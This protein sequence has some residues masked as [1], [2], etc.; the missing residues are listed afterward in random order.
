MQADIVN[1]AISRLSLFSDTMLSA[2]PNATNG[3]MKNAVT[4]TAVFA[5]ADRIHRQNH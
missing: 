2:V 5:A 4:R 3:L 1:A